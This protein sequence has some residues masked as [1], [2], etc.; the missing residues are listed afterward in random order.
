MKVKYK[1]IIDLLRQQK[2]DKEP[3]YTSFT[4][5]TATTTKIFDKIKNIL[6]RVHGVTGVPL[7]YVIRVVLF[8][9]DKDDDPPFVEKDT[10]YMSFN[11]ETTAHAPILSDNTN[12]EEKFKSLRPMDR[13]FPPSSLT[14]RRF[15]PFTLHILAS[16]VHGNTSRS[17]LPNRMGVKPGVPSTIIYLGGTRL[18]LWSLRFF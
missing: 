10:K 17:S 14:P 3:E 16:Q 18:T 1:G 6:A 2:Q 13:L 12:Y 5:D 7:V 9:D 11:M 8:P 4:L 15:G